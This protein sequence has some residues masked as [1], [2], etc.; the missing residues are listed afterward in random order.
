MAVPRPVRPV[1]NEGAV[2]LGVRAGLLLRAGARQSMLDEVD[3][4]PPNA[5]RTSPKSCSVERVGS[6]GACSGMLRHGMRDIVDSQLGRLRWD[7]GRKSLEGDLRTGN[8]EV[9]LG[10]EVLDDE[11][12]REQLARA[13]KVVAGIA[14][15]IERAQRHAAQRMVGVKNGGYLERGEPPLSEDEFAQRLQFERLELLLEGPCH[16]VFG[17]DQMLW[18]HYISVESDDDGTPTRAEMWG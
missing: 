18:G 14:Q 9:A 3:F 12:L 6:A 4:D 7:E 13:R 2:A 10:I 11:S 5:G 17:D 15:H 8:R 16:F 1:E